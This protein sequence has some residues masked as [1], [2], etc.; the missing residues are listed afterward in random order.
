LWVLIGVSVFVSFFSVFLSYGIMFFFGRRTQ[1]WD[2]GSTRDAH[3]KLAS[4]I[5]R[6]EAIKEMI[7]VAYTSNSA[8]RMLELFDKKNCKVDRLK[9]LLRNPVTLLSGEGKEG[10]IPNDA[11]QINN[12]L[13]QMRAHLLGDIS[14]K[15]LGIERV[16]K[17]EIKFYDGEPVLRGMVIDGNKGFFSIYTSHKDLDTID[18][19][20]T[21]SATLR[22]STDGGYEEKIL[23]DFV[24]WFNL[25][26]EYGGKRFDESTLEKLL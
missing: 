9:I 8:Y 25:V 7:I 18:Y 22:L 5:S 3:Q 10:A 1:D 26:W 23:T 6:D 16:K 11:S 2:F 19:S 4:I 14:R 21:G 20:A 13:S 17:L 24:T 15:R 12:R